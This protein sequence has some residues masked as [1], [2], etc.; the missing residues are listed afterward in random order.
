MEEEN[1]NRD[2]NSQN[3][4]EREH[5]LRAMRSLEAWVIGGINP[6]PSQIS[7]VTTAIQT[8]GLEDE[9]L[10]STVTCFSLGHRSLQLECLSENVNI[11]E[12]DNRWQGESVHRFRILIDESGYED[13][14][15]D[16]LTTFLFPG[17][18][19]VVRF[20][21]DFRQPSHGIPQRRTQIIWNAKFTWRQIKQKIADHTYDFDFITEFINIGSMSYGRVTQEGEEA[22]SLR[23]EEDEEAINS[24]RLAVD[25]LPEVVISENGDE[26]ECS[27][28]QE[29]FFEGEPAKQLPCEHLYH[30][31]CIVIW[32]RRKNSCPL[33]RY[34]PVL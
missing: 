19:I 30:S 5:V 25:E 8:R 33:C 4:R 13:Q 10:V 23:A 3:Q 24:V 22:N 18:M 16:Y 21:I 20:I 26:V 14:R 6:P 15:E 7:T 17:N 28:C 32:F 29:T 12:L 9:H 31:K 34:E 2:T 1:R 11:H 27:I